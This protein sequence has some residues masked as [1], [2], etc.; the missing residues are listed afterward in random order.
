MEPIDDNSAQSSA[1]SESLQTVPIYNLDASS[2]DSDSDD[3][4]RSGPPVGPPV[5]SSTITSITSGSQ[6]SIM[7]QRQR[8][9]V[10]QRSYTT[11]IPRHERQLSELSAVAESVQTRPSVDEENFFEEEED[12]TSEEEPFQPVP[13][14]SGQTETPITEPQLVASPSIQYE[15][16]TVID[17]PDIS[18]GTDNRGLRPLNLLHENVEKGLPLLTK[19]LKLHISS[20][21]NNSSI[22][23][24]RMLG[25]KDFLQTPR[26]RVHQLYTIK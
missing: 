4:Q 1:P 2:S 15:S 19:G 24:R 18:S 23:I 17:V 26:F 12:S 14:L 21:S 20:T 11:P 22:R 10:P 5:D 9:Q 7:S 13:R 8:V 3:P 16:R 25:M 6:T